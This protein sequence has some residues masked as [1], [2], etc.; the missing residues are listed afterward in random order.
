MTKALCRALSH[1]TQQPRDVRGSRPGDHLTSK[2]LSRNAFL[3]KILVMR[4]ASN[5]WNGLTRSTNSIYT[6]NIR[7][8]SICAHTDCHENDENVLL[9]H[10]GRDKMAAIFQ[11]TFSNA[12]TWMKM[13]EFRL[14]C[15]W[16][17]FPRVQLTM[18][19]H[20]FRK[21]LGA[22]QATSHYLNQWWLVYWRIYA[23]LGLNELNSYFLHI[24]KR[25][26]SYSVVCNMQTQ[27]YI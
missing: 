9:T 7:I 20:L 10:W 22:G 17:L 12:F 4:D 1:P 27:Q 19:H 14:K 18:F 13:F 23:S 6:T 24:S 21:W 2:H 11:T 8:V 5:T 26:V 25:L 16:N 3:V 15:Y